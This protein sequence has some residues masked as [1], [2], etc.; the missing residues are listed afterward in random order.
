MDRKLVKQSKK[1]SWLLRHAGP[2]EG[3]E[4]D[5]AG[6]V[7]VAQVL[8]RL[9]MS[10]SRL[11]EI[12][13]TNNKRRLQMIDGKIRACQG[14]STDCRAVTVDALEASWRRLPGDGPIYHGT[15]VDVLEA[16]AREGIRPIA[17]TH[18]HCA[19]ALK[20]V[21]GKRAQVAVM[22]ELSV[23]R[24]REAGFEVYEAPNGVILVRHVPP[25]CVVGVQAISKRAR[26]LKPELDALFG[27]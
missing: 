4:M 24:L 14:H 22:L 27:L 12:V 18:V 20:S 26:A 9:S 8:S 11:Q 2:S 5:P 15:R 17:R 3:L 10:P 6:W 16:I 1:L 19:P 7:P 21:V 25:G 13:R 23:P